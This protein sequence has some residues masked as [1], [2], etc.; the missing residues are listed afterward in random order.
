MLLNGTDLT[1]IAAGETVYHAYQAGLM[2]QEKGIKARVLDM[3]SIKPVD[4]EA[5]RK[6]QKK[7][8]ELSLWKSIVSLVVWEL[9]WLRRFP[10]SDSGTHYRHP[11]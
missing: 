5:I 11:R 7:P 9:L 6:R 4:A 2:L 3:S 8:E 10:K 1:I